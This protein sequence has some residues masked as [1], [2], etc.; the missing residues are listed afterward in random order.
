MV[1]N[2]TK[3]FKIY[4][5]GYLKN[6]YF[7]KNSNRFPFL[8]WTNKAKSDSSGLAPLYARVTVK[9]KEWKSL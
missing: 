4:Q 9:E 7:M 5:F 6:G 3:Q 2:D 8:F 1:S